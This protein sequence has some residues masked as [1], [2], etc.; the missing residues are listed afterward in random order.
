VAKFD[1][2]LSFA[3]EDREVARLIASGLKDLGVKAFYDDD[4]QADLL[5]ENLYEYLADLYSN[6]A[7]YCIVIVSKDYVKKRWTRHEWRASQERA[8]ASIDEAYILPLRLDDAELPGLLSTVGFLDLRKVDV[9]RAIQI[10][11][12][13]IQ[14]AARYNRKIQAAEQSFHLSDFERVISILSTELNSDYIKTD[15]LALRFLADAHMML[16]EYQKPQALLRC[17]LDNASQDAESL[18]LL[19]VCHMRLG[20]YSAAES[21]YERVLSLAPRH[22][23]AVNDLRQIQEIRKGQRQMMHGPNDLDG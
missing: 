4:E 6:R 16:G 9:E 11:A 2:A 17:V 15:R 3:G 18:F 10:I 8:L 22:G 13:K 20:D 14:S 21:L 1:V 12:M 5:G 23:A 19:A 7:S